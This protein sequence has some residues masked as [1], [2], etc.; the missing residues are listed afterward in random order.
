MNSPES[1]SSNRFNHGRVKTEENVLLRN[2]ASGGGAELKRMDKDF[3]EDRKNATLNFVFPDDH[4]THSS[5]SS[6]NHQQH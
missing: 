3:E 2:L 1:F 6:H 5:S 4:N